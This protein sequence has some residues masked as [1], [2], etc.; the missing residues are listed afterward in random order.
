MKPNLFFQITKVDEAN[1]LVTGRAVQEVPDKADEI[2][3]YEGSKPYFEK[4]TEEIAGVTKGKSLGNVRSMHSNVAAGKVTQMDFNDPAKAIDITAKIVDNNEWDKVLE[5]VHTGF[6]IGG[7]YVKKWADPA[8]AKLTRYIAKPSEI[9][10]V[11]RPCIPTALFFDIKKADG[12]VVQKAFKPVAPVPAVDP[13]VAAVDEIAALLTANPGYAVELAAL[14]K[15]DFSDKQ[16]DKAAASG[17]ALP[18]GSYPIE[19]AEDL[20]NA[21]QAFG[22]A[23]DPDKVK[24]HIKTRAKALGAEDQLPDD[25]K[26][27]GAKMGTSGAVTKGDLDTLSTN[28]GTTAPMLTKPAIGDLVSFS[29]GEK[30]VQGEIKDIKGSNLQIVTADGNDYLYCNV[31]QLKFNDGDGQDGKPSWTYNSEDAG[32]AFDATSHAADKVD[33][34]GTLTKVAGLAL[35]KGM[36]GVAQFACVLHG[37]KCLQQ[38]QTWE[39]RAEQDGS[40]MPGKLTDWLKTGGELL[41][42]MVKEEVAELTADP[43]EDPGDAVLSAP[44]PLYLSEKA[45]GLMKIGARNSKADLEHLQ[46]AHD[47]L[48]K[49]GA[50]C[51]ADNVPANDGAG[52]RGNNM[53]GNDP[54]TA[55][56]SDTMAPA[57]GDLKAAMAKLAEVNTAHEAALK[58]LADAHA[59]ELAKRDQ[60]IGD[61]GKRLKVVEDAPRPA[62]GRVF[63]VNKNGT[64]TEVTQQDGTKVGLDVDPV[65]DPTTGKQDD[66]ATMFKALHAQGGQR[67]T[68]L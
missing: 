16:R 66:V 3:D 48:A 59:A 29:W 25:W 33:V 37:I 54:G 21:V 38:D 52:T 13:G 61:L 20:K 9:S 62:K 1:R 8:D 32:D 18:D 51:K 31:G 67:V 64:Q 30:E 39:A 40:A 35:K 36:T 63:A 26:D 56:Y 23:K 58:K 68:K 10:L 42:E 28:Q 46:S 55:G 15:R 4:W 24:A 5:G 22:R 2:F 57:K 11:D 44:M 47:H 7:D 17:A 45:G 65:K 19:T 6:S 27:G 12:T 49:C 53:Q 14:A 34:L 41:T 60:L 50:M 43:A